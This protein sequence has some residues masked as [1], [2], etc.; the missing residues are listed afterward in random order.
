MCIQTLPQ[1]SFK[2]ILIIL[3][4]Y[5]LINLISFTDLGIIY[6]EQNVQPELLQDDKEVV[7]T[8]SIRF[9]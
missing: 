2:H 6:S 3:K 4:C 5:I 9:G 7:N 1:V 8:R